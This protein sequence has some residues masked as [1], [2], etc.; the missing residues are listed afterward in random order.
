M[1]ILYWNINNFSINKIAAGGPPPA[2]AQAA[3]RLAYIVED[4]LRG[5]VGGVAPGIPDII[6]IV[7]VYSRI[8]EVGS[9]GIVLRAGSNAGQAVLQLLGQ[10]RADAV[11]GAGGSN[12][13]VVPPLN[14]GELGQREAV[15]VFFNATTVQFTGPN[16]FY[17]LYGPPGPIIGQSQPVTAATY[18]VR[19]PYPGAWLG[20]LPAL[21]RTT[22][23]AGAA[24]PLPENELAGEW[25]YYT[26]APARPIPSPA[27]PAVPPNRIQFP[28]L[29]CRGPFHTRFLEVG[30]AGRTI[31]LFCVHTSPATAVNAVQALATV[32]E[33]AAVAA[34]EV[35]VLLGDFNVDTFSGNAFAYNTLLVGSGG[36]Y[37]LELDPRVAHAG[38]LVPARKPY[39]MTH[40]LPTAQATPLN[41]IGVATD[42]RHNVYPRSGY[43]G[44]AWPVLNDTGAIDNILTA[45]GGGLAAPAASH[46]TVVNTLTGTP[47]NAFAAPGGV[48]PELTGGLTV[49]TTLPFN[50]LVTQPPASPVVGGIDPALLFVV[51]WGMLFQWWTYV[52]KVYST[53]DHLP[54]ITD[55]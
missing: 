28:N 23:F 25:Q 44:G 53:S 36:I 55:I 2:P 17:Q 1:R 19:A 50:M 38:G 4:V 45:Y 37:T 7:E 52:G 21:G 42:P 10:I 6:V 3:D 11:L 20:A 26:A 54:L 46:I 34:G 9:E 16:L 18:A 35:N 51:A 8:R 12:W 30:G 29:R 27:P 39:C 13:C 15:A 47:Y 40:L 32:P 31:N 24:A 33:I 49:P 48:T 5:S 14:L 22:A 43:M 41:N